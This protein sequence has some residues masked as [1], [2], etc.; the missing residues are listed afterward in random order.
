MLTSTEQAE[1]FKLAKRL[2][3]ATVRN[4]A[5]AKRGVSTTRMAFANIKVAEDKLREYLKEAG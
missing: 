2:A 3:S 4:R 5:Q 1:I